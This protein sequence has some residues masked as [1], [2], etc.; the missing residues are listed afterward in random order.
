MLEYPQVALDFMNRD[1]ADFVA[2]REQ[3]LDLLSAQAHD[4]KVD[5]LLD[6]LLT[7]PATTSP[8]KNA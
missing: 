8:K 5:N 1:H 2:L 6:E 4:S 3:L 7:T